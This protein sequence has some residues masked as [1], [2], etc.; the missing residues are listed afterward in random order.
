MMTDGTPPRRALILEDDPALTLAVRVILERQG[1]EVVAVAES[2]TAAIQ[3]AERARPDAL[4]VVLA[5][6][7]VH[8]VRIVSALRAASP[9][10]AVAVL[11]PFPRLRRPA[12]EA[13]AAEVVEIEDLRYLGRWAQHFGEPPR[14]FC[15]CC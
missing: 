9:E 5:L 7:G 8:G 2:A 1:F 14:S 12:F 10:S 11:S 15:E 4:V 3:G 13:G 6:S